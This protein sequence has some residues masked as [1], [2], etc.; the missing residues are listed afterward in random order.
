MNLLSIFTGNWKK[1]GTAASDAPAPIAPIPVVPV[2]PAVPNHAPTALEERQRLLHALLLG[3]GVAAF[4]LL[5][6]M[7]L[8][9]AIAVLLWACSP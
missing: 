3:L 5:A 2:V 6:S 4:S 9:A 8:T 1:S 7:T